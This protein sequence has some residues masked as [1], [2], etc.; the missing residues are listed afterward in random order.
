MGIINLLFLWRFIRSPGLRSVDMPGTLTKLSGNG[1]G[2]VFRKMLNFTVILED[3]I[4][5]KCQDTTITITDNK[6][7]ITKYRDL[8]KN[9][10]V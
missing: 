9:K 8:N 7:M 1:V 2:V 6:N 10:K 5:Q 4:M 3:D